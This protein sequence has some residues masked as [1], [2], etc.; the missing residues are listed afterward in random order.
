MEAYVAALE[1]KLAE[2]S[3]IQVDQIKKNQLANAASEMGAI[4]EMTSFINSISVQ[5]AGQA[6]ANVANPL[7]GSVLSTIKAETGEEG[8]FVLP[9]MGYEYGQ[10]EPTICEEIMR[11]HHSKHHNG[12][13][14]F[15]INF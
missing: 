13:S 15:K 8:A 6:Q 2:A 3:G 5:A 14:F 4:N 10:L 7:I 11:I 12:F 1:A 9:K